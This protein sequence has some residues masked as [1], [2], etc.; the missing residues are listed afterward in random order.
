M[1]YLVLCPHYTSQEHINNRNW[2]TPII[3]ENYIP[4]KTKT[5]VPTIN[6]TSLR[7]LPLHD[8]LPQLIQPKNPPHIKIKHPPPRKRTQNPTHPCKIPPPNPS[9]PPRRVHTP[10]NLSGILLRGNRIRIAVPLTFLEEPL[11]GHV[12]RCGRET[13]VPARDRVGGQVC[14]DAAGTDV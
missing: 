1:R 4:N 12:Q 10:H 13:Q 3:N 6:T 5:Y 8:N 14:A 11:N 9:T 2:R 7:L